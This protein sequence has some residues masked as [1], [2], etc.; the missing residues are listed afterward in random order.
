MKMIKIIAAISMLIAVC[1]FPLQA[2]TNVVT[3]STDLADIAKAVGG[4]KVTVT[5]L[6]LGS[7]NPHTVE[8]RPSQVARLSRA[9]L[10]VR[11]G[12]D[13]DMWADSLISASRNRSVQQGGKGYVD[14]SINIRKL[15]VPSDRVDGSQGDIHVHGNPH[16][17]LD[18]ENAQVV[19]RN[20]MLGLKRVSPGDADYFEKNYRSFSDRI[21]DRMTE[22]KK[23][24]APHKGKKI[25]TYHKTWVYFIR[26]FGLKEIGN[27]EPKPGI[28]PSPS[29]L[30]SLVSDMKSEDA[31]VI[32]MEKF[33]SRKFPD[34]IA[35]QTGAKIVEVPVSVGG[36][37]G[38]GSYI[39]LIDTIV[40]RLSAAL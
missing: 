22:W 10:F 40:K 21:D 14:A 29:H 34:A 35:R 7:Q 28:P 5:A 32:L 11:I 4:D 13:L 19:A 15:E 24:L 30:R 27:V 38:V 36:E 26:R 20:I 6:M 16:Y 37:K 33:Y 25:V 8:P 2:K 1:T 3:T 17:W 23:T 31:K 12:M 18:P 39:E 9:D